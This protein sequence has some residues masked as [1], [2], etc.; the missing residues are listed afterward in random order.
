MR[1]LRVMSIAI[2]VLAV[3][4]VAAMNGCDAD[5]AAHQMRGNDLKALRI[6]EVLCESLPSS[7]T[8]VGTLAVERRRLIVRVANTGGRIVDLSIGERFGNPAGDSEIEMHKRDHPTSER[9]YGLGVEIGWQSKGEWNDSGLHFKGWK[10]MERPDE[11][12]NNAWQVEVKPGETRSF[13]CEMESW[14]E[15]W[16]GD[17]FRAFIL[18]TESRRI[19]EK[20]CVR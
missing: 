4:S 19:S 17:A 13:S 7:P 12:V 14:F 6:T 11:R 9:A 8:G 15:K 2:V 1:T 5:Q 16:N 10:P 20:E 3:G 18:N